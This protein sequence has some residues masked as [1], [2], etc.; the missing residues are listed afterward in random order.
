MVP[1]DN[2]DPEETCARTTRAQEI[3]QEYLARSESDPSVD[4]DALLALHPNEREELTELHQAVAF[5]DDLRVERADSIQPTIRHRFGGDLD[6]SVMLEEDDGSCEVLDPDIGASAEG[7]FGRYRVK[8]EVARGGQGVV[9]RVWDSELRRHL[10]MKVLHSDRSRPMPAAR[11]GL[12]SRVLARFLEEAQVTGQLDH[13]GF[14]PV[15]EIGIGPMG[16]V[17]FTM[18]L[19]RGESLQAVYGQYH[20]GQ[21]DWSLTRVLGIL[22]RVCEA[23]AYAHEK[24]VVHRDLKPAN[25]MVGR[26]GAVYVMDWGLA[27]VLGRPETKDIRI[28]EDATITQVVSGRREKQESDP[29]SPLVTV[30][31]DVIGTPAYMSPEQAR[32]QAELLDRRAD[33]YSLGAMLY[34][35]LAGHPP[36]YIPGVQ[37]SNRQVLFRLLEGAPK[38]LVEIA[39]SAPPEL[40]AISERAMARDRMERYA[41]MGELAAD[42][43]A[44][45]ENRVVTAF[46]S[47]PWAQ[48]KKLIQRNRVSA[49]IVSVALL[50]VF[51]ATIGSSL[52]LASKNKALAVA[53]DDA[54]DKTQELLSLSAAQAIEELE[55]GAGQLWPVAPERIQQYK[56]WLGKAGEVTHGLPRYRESLNALRLQSLDPEP[57]DVS[58]DPHPAALAARQ[59]LAVVKAREM[60]MDSLRTRLQD[61]EQAPADGL[62][63]CAASLALAREQAQQ[64]VAVARDVRR[65]KFA[66]QDDQ[67]LHDRLERLVKGLEELMDPQIGLID[68]RTPER[69]MGI[70]RRLQLAEEMQEQAVSSA[71]LEAWRQAQS[72][73][74]NPA[75]SPAYA[76]L[77]IAPQLGLVPLGKDPR[78]GFWEFADVRSGSIPTRTAEGELQLVPGSAVVLVLLPGGPFTMGSQATDPKG[79]RYD[80]AALSDETPMRRMHAGPFFLS[81]FELTQDQWQRV[82]G[83][84]P[85]SS[86][87]GAPMPGAAAG[88]LV[89]TR[90]PVESVSWEECVQVLGWMGMRLPTEAQW[91]YAARAGT[92]TIWSSGDTLAELSAAANIADTVGAKAGRTWMEATESDTLN[93]GYAV[94]SPVGLF[95][96]NGFGLHDMHGNLWEWC[97]DA[98]GPYDPRMSVADNEAYGKVI[99]NRTIR[100]GA[101][102]FPSGYARSSRRYKNLPVFKVAFLG[103]RP[104][105]ELH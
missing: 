71:F 17:F 72:S 23:M 6:P 78:S 94:H 88:V 74:A 63:E 103:V 59:A 60:D 96:P 95:A 16:K 31:G 2:T 98:Y 69:G 101:Y 3:F 76:G 62:I 105:R 41:D 34:H 45:L 42:V 13:P 53:R 22:L 84:N 49:G 46:A 100:G 70:A 12:G 83:T 79:E 7:T 11:P 86:A 35:L 67:W 57:I 80:K 30:D 91:E 10:A 75:E 85:S 8:G 40:I 97:R 104:M 52:I 77:S 93:D 36:N 4:F 1:E 9:L 55:Q 90:H 27:R 15:H 65:F 43:R 87:E 39:P 58:M 73:I 102:Y 50:I 38:P 20:K 66:S 82:A 24:G 56:A 68:G 28:R 32:G 37:L 81:K 54:R 33:V 89:G 5:L 47:G 25:V 44:Y 48:F 92:E 21:A 51:S 19:V 18:K 26:H 61:S 29:D 64:L 99:G 14:V